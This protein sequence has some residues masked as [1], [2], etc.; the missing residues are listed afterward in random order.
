MPPHH[1]TRTLKILNLSFCDRIV[2]NRKGER[3]LMLKTTFA[4]AEFANPFM[5]ASGVHCMTTEDLE[6]LKAS[7]AGAYITKSSTLEKEKVIHS[8]VMLT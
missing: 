2:K 5:N 7:Q 3:F 6:E 1:L 8:H 4:N